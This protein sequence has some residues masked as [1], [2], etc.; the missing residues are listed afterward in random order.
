MQIELNPT[1]RKIVVLALK[2]FKPIIH[3]PS[4]GY[5]L[6]QSYKGLLDKLKR[7]EGLSQE[8]DS[9]IKESKLITPSP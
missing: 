1:E 4:T 8:I 3:E 5:L 9:T 2:F 7:D 6:R